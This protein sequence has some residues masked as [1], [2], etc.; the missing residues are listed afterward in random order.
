MSKYRLCKYLL[1]LL[2]LLSMLTL[3]GCADI[4]GYDNNSV[5][6][7]QADDGGYLVVGRTSYTDKDRS[8]ESLIIKTDDLGS[9]EWSQA[10]AGYIN[11]L[12]PTD[13]G[14][15][16][17]G[18]TSSLIK[19][20]SLGNLEWSKTYPD[21]RIVS[22]QQTGEGGYILA[23]SNRLLKVDHMGNEEWFRTFD[24]IKINSV[25]Q[26]GDGG[27]ILAGGTSAYTALL[28]KT[29]AQGELEWSQTFDKG[30]LYSVE[31]ILDQSSVLMGS[32]HLL[33]C[34]EQG[35][36]KWSRTYDEMRLFYSM[37]L[38]PDKGFILAGESSAINT[39]EQGNVNWS[40]PYENVL[41]KTNDL[42][43]I[44]W[45]RSYDNV[46]I[47]FV[48]N[49]RDGGYILT[50]NAKASNISSAWLS[51][52]DAQGKQ[53][54]A[55]TFGGRADYFPTLRIAAALLL[56]PLFNLIYFFRFFRDMKARKERP[57]PWFIKFFLLGPVAVAW[58]KTCRIPKEGEQPPRG[59]KT[60][61][62]AKHLILPWSIY[63]LIVP[64]AFVCAMI[65]NENPSQHEYALT[66]VLYAMLYAAAI[67]P[68]WF[69]STLAAVII[70]AATTPKPP[71]IQAK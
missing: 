36:E 4:S 28:A 42:G 31:L 57:V 21:S 69:I 35:N 14:G 38:T 55:R 44:T 39:D 70:M 61:H 20:D 25:Q 22:V 56:L 1:V 11:S 5:A 64:A 59:K 24:D 66:V 8:V 13:D 33:I 49:T 6:V 2:I 29:D 30:S 65:I 34:D 60:H 41:I 16:I 63:V 71:G 48:D 3:T 18:E 67:L 53:E 10:F 7:I 23:G 54:W 52:T 37:Q 51:K 32:N 47:T 46:A 45:T 9:K 58:Y 12:L 26:T 19:V 40:Q 17:L 50:G 43:V 68:F 15:Y 62:F 27:Y